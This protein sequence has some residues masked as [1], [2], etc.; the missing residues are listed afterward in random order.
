[1][2]WAF[3]TRLLTTWLARRTPSR[4]VCVNSY[5]CSLAQDGGPVVEDFMC[6]YLG[7]HSGGW[8]RMPLPAQMTETFKG[9]GGNMACKDSGIRLLLLTWTGGLQG[10]RE[11]WSAV[12]GQRKAKCGGQRALL[13]VCREA[14]APCS[15]RADAVKEQ[16]QNPTGS[17]SPGDVSG[18]SQGSSVMGSGPWL[19]EPETFKTEMR[20]SWVFP[21]ICFFRPPERS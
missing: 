1:M 19:G 15:G 6:G 9:Y 10:K 16:S 21:R 13:V 11:R 14:F 12:N 4:A 18:L 7:K 2:R 17:R 3:A 5:R 20:I 8:R